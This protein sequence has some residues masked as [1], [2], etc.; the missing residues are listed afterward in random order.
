L[1]CSITNDGSLI[2]CL[3]SCDPLLQ[4]CEQDGTG[5]Y[6]SSSGYFS[7]Y[8]TVGDIPGNEPCGYINDCNPGLICLDATSLVDCAGASCCASICDMAEPVC[9]SVGTECTA[10]YDEGT[11]PPDEED[12]G[13][14]VVPGN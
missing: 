7:C 3:Y 2:K 10:F 14:C 4:D 8:A 13:I 12:V 1:N 5:C 9:P 6:W 11:A